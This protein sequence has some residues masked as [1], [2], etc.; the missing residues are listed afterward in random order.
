MESA[1]RPTVRF[2]FHDNQTVPGRVVRKILCNDVGLSE[3]E[4]KRLL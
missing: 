4:A 1:G 2:S 3:D